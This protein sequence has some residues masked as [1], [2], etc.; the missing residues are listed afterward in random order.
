[1]ILSALLRERFSI[2]PSGLGEHKNLLK[3]LLVQHEIDWAPYLKPRLW[4]LAIA[5]LAADGEEVHWYV[6]EYTGLQRSWDFL[7]G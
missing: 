6:H 3:E 7:T 1:M 4:V 2:I 5:A